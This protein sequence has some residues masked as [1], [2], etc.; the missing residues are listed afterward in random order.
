MLC[1][2]YIAYVNTGDYYTDSDPFGQASVNPGD[3]PVLSVPR[4][5][6]GTA[7]RK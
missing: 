6:P 4:P 3:V 5:P 2:F 1:P 7:T